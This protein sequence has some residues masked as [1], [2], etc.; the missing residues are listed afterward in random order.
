MYNLHTCN[1][2]HSNMSTRNYYA[3]LQFHK[4][5]L[6][7]RTFGFT[8]SNVYIFFGPNAA[9]LRT[10]CRHHYGP[11]CR[12]F[13]HGLSSRHAQR[14]SL[15]IPQHILLLSPTPS[16]L[17]PSRSRTV[18]VAMRPTVTAPPASK[19]AGL[20]NCSQLAA[21]THHCATRPAPDGHS[22]P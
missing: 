13:T 18:Q 3:Y 10:Q 7:L 4:Y 8:V 6:L 1:T 12:S 9:I 20:R 19:I 22:A 11:Q 14:I 5:I 21:T 15:P 16:E 17:S 2:A